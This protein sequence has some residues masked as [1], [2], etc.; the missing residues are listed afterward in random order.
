MGGGGCVRVLVCVGLTGSDVGTSE[1]C[2][3]CCGVLKDEGEEWGLSQ[4]WGRRRRRGGTRGG[5]DGMSGSAVYTC[6]CVWATTVLTSASPSLES[7]ESRPEQQS[8]G[9]THTHVG[10]CR[11][12]ESFGIQSL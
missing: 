1:F 6:A 12:W 9:Y 11:F 7:I 8:R 3:R 10:I 4:A 2:R 5:W